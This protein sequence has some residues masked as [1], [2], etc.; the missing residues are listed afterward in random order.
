MEVNN[1]YEYIRNGTVITIYDI[2]TNDTDTV[3]IPKIIDGY[4]VKTVDFSH[5]RSWK[6]YGDNHPEFKHVKT[7]IISAN[8][9]T[10]YIHTRTFYNLEKI[11]FEKDFDG[12]AETVKKIIRMWAFKNKASSSRL[13]SITFMGN[14]K[15][16]YQDNLLISE[17]K[18][19][20]AV[21]RESFTIPNN[22]S[23]IGTESILPTFKKTSIINYHQNI[24]TIEDNPFG[25]NSLITK[26][27]ENFIPHINSI[28]ATIKNI[29]SNL[30]VD[31]GWHVKAKA[32]HAPFVINGSK[33]IIRTQAE[34]VSEEALK[35]LSKLQLSEV[36]IE[37]ENSPFEIKNRFLI[38]KENTLV[39]PIRKV[40][41]KA[42]IYIPEYVTKSFIEGIRPEYK[43]ESELSNESEQFKSNEVEFIS[44]KEKK[45]FYR[46]VDEI[47]IPFTNVFVLKNV[48][49]KDKIEISLK[50]LKIP[51]TRKKEPDYGILID[52][53]FKYV[54]ELIIPEGVM[55]LNFD[56]MI[57]G[58]SFALSKL[59]LPSTLSLTNLLPK[60]NQ[61]KKLMLVVIKPTKKIQVK[62]NYV[63]FI[64]AN[65]KKKQERDL[66]YS[67]SYSN[68]PFP[69]YES[70][71]S[72]VTF[73]YSYI[74][75]FKENRLIHY[76]NG[77]YYLRE[78]DNVKTYTLIKTDFVDSFEIEK[79]IDGIKVA[80]ISDNCLD[81]V[82]NKN[83]VDT[84]NFEDY[85]F[86][87][88]KKRN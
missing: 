6:K 38:Y 83:D 65:L 70:P 53:S 11:I 20:L 2:N 15:F 7:L 40:G 79:E 66:F 51:P 19:L 84:R 37:N 33:L 48:V 21:T 3:H 86:A 5:P 67:Y 30:M 35:E 29:G 49:A 44:L 57:D 4:P 85:E 82:K 1:E 24:T 74:S 58:T 25:L 50:D 73:G 13:P 87:H 54:K 28:P 88:F 59:V 10:F 78:E 34:N 71:Y 32:E 14:T 46:T 17:D 42:P 23:V 43:N 16:I 36:I 41:S 52:N 31:S 47:K 55:H 75:Q 81:N 27:A 12:D 64:I 76:K 61:F 22:V 39:C 60:L 63:H 56:K 62:F 68:T 26:Q 80:Y 72:N 45:A 69:E 9:E 8:L 18:L 77:Y